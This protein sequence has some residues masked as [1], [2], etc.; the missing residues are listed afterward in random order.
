[1]LCC[2]VLCCDV[3]LCWDVLSCAMLRYAALCCAQ[4]PGSDVYYIR[5]PPL[6]SAVEA[7]R[8]QQ[9]VYSTAI[10]VTDGSGDGDGGE[11]ASRSVGASTATSLSSAGTMVGLPQTTGAQLDISTAIGVSG[12]RD[13]D[14]CGIRLRSSITDVD[15]E[16]QN[17][18][19]EYTDVYVQF[20]DCSEAAC[21]S[22]TLSVDTTESNANM[23][24][25]VNR[26]VCSSGSVLYTD[27]ALD[28]H[29]DAAAGGGS[30]ELRA[31]L[32]HSVVEGFLGAGSERAVTRRVYPSSPQEAENVQLF[33]RCGAATGQCTCEFRAT[34]SWSLR[35]SNAQLSSDNSSDDPSYEYV[36]YTLSAVAVVFMFGFFGYRA[37]HVY[38]DKY[39]TEEPLVMK[40]QK[41]SEK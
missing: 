37:R 38:R 13:G 28:D 41:A 20:W 11:S 15:N 3:L 14:A 10:T 18:L 27:L 17:T 12:M 4:V 23:S 30:V 29:S 19:V 34:S 36:Y 2:D 21:A 32:D 22:M 40:E 39:T 31:L 1:M 33:A 6:H 24:I 5:T 16:E 9:E 8:D 25:P 7:L 35:S 26:S